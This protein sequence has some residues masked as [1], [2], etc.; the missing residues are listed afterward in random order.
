MKKLEPHA[1]I[2]YLVGYDSTNIFWIWIPSKQKVISTCDVTFNETL[3]YDLKIPDAIQL[4]QLSEQI[5]EV[6]KMLEL[7][8][9]SN[10]ELVNDSNEKEEPKVERN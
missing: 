9:L 4:N 7:L 1:H 3:F 10:S 5:L 8:R 6:I 2:G